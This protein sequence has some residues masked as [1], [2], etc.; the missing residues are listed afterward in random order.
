MSANR[1][2]CI[3]RH[4]AGFSAAPTPMQSAWFS[5]HNCGPVPGSHLVATRTHPD[6]GVPLSAKGVKALL[7]AERVR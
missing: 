5:L 3:S 7:L 6:A 4:G 2:V 1:A